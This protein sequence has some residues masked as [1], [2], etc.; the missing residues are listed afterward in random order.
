MPMSQPVAVTVP[1]VSRSWEVKITFAVRPVVPAVAHAA[2]A[3]C[4]PNAVN[5]TAEMITIG[6]EDVL[7]VI[8]CCNRDFQFGRLRRAL[9]LHLGTPR[10]EKLFRRIPSAF[11]ICPREDFEQEPPAAFAVVLRPQQETRRARVGI[12]SGG[13]A[14][15]A[16]DLRSGS[17]RS[18]G[19]DDEI[20]R[21]GDGFRRRHARA[22]GS[23][24]VTLDGVHD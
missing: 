14:D 7:I 16:F 1:P 11:K 10:N 5:R 20:P 12:H 3:E 22:P 24:R 6:S 9:T 21:S 19:I 15:G 2:K 8:S 17:S 13:R 23:P 4:A 18:P